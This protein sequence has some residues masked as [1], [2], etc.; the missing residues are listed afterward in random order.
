MAL[1]PTF[2]SASEVEA[3]CAE[4][5]GKE[6]LQLR[7]KKSKPPQFETLLNQLEVRSQMSERF[8]PLIECPGYVFPP[9]SKLS[10][11]S[12]CATALWRGR[13]LGLTLTKGSRIWDVTGGSGVDTWGLEMAG[14]HTLVTEPDRGLAALHV[15]NARI[16]EVEREVHGVASEQFT[17][18]VP[19]DALYVDPSRLD[20]DGKRVY[21]PK[22]CFPN[23]LVELPRWLEQAENVWIK[24]SP[25][26][27]PDE[28]LHWFPNVQAVYLL[29]VH[30]EMKEVLV[31]VTRQPNLAPGRS[32]IDLYPDGTERYRFAIDPQAQKPTLDHPR[33]YL[34]D[35]DAAL[36]AGRGIPTLA[37]TFAMQQLHPDSRLL[38]SHVLH[39]DFPGRVFQVDGIHAPFKGDWPNGAS[40]VV[41]G[42]PD[43]ADSIR[44]Q[45]KL[46]ENA[47][48]YLLATVWGETERGFIAARRVGA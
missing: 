8:G 6:P 22:D 14:F 15:H 18:E 19:V 30:R 47:E 7:L 2:P 31:H 33:T 34:Y 37:E 39:T 35:A 11:A 36:V 46:K 20:T 25:M 21:H 4:N 27:D 5:V 38:T 24:L 28:V 44:S 29:S 10:Q 43:K 48:H 13:E 32:A 26:V 12:S 45:M 16:L 1:S 23:P 3:F 42:Y 17:P 40:V 9:K 41:R